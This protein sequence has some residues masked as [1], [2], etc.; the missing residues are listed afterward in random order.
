MSPKKESILIVEDA[1]TMQLLVEGILRS[2]GYVHIA[3]C[4]SC[5]IADQIIKKQ[6]FD[7]IFCDWNLVGIS[8]IQWL[9]QIRPQHQG[10]FVMM[11]GENDPMKIKEAKSF[12]ADD[13]LVKPF[14]PVEMKEVFDRIQSVVV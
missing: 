5:E 8:G 2:L 13:F 4:F 11:T 3:K 12:G 14:G 10:K 7:W 6:K 1:S 9:K